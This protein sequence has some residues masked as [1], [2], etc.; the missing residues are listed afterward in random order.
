MGTIDRLLGLPTDG[1][2]HAL[3]SS[4]Y[5]SE[6][7]AYQPVSRLSTRRIHPEYLSGDN[8]GESIESSTPCVLTRQEEDGTACEEQMDTSS[9]SYT[10]NEPSHEN[11]EVCEAGD[12]IVDLTEDSSH[13]K[14]ID[15]PDHVKCPTLPSNA[16]I[17]YENQT[18]QRS[19]PSCSESAPFRGTAAYPDDKLS[20]DNHQVSSPSRSPSTSSIP[21]EGDNLST[22]STSASFSAISQQTTPKPRSDRRA[23]ET[24]ILEVAFLKNP[25]PTSK[26]IQK[27]ATDTQLSPASIKVRH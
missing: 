24:A 16:F 6:R 27:L 15:T 26:E 20:P 11:G 25:S 5:R 1:A 3:I 4:M 19:P 21:S 23:R 17:G 2:R 12:R 7:L 8:R 18:Y 22:N 9:N 13:M 14:I 10:E